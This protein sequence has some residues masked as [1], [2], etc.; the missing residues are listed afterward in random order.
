[1]RN[2]SSSLKTIASAQADFRAN[3][4]DWNHV[5]DYW[6]ADIAGLY[7]LEVQ[8]FAIKLIELSVAAADDRPQTDLSPL[9]VKSAK[10]GFWF[11]ALP[12][13]DET[14]RGP[15]RFAACTF[16]QSLVEGRYGTYVISERG[17]VRKKILGHA[18]GIDAHPTEAE[19]KAEAWEVFD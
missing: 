18:R 11:R 15:D 19:L 7:A 12:H 6:R 16:P 4:R 8:G 14:T 9:A 10:A 1:V 13:A 17:V 3:D 2:A 5:N